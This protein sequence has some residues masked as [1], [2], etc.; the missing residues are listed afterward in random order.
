MQEGSE[1]IGK[2]HIQTRCIIKGIHRIFFIGWFPSSS[3][4]VDLDSHHSVQAIR[5]ESIGANGCD[6]VVLR[7]YLFSDSTVAPA[8]YINRDTLDHNGVFAWHVWL[9]ANC[10]TGIR[11]NQ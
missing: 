2:N 7:S 10:S 9:T 8:T 6:Y 3:F 11:N 4:G 5:T 1:H